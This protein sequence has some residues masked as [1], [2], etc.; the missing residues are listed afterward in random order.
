MPPA[1]PTAPLEPAGAPPAT[2][3]PTTVALFREALPLLLGIFWLLASW[4]VDAEAKRVFVVREPWGQRRTLGYSCLAVGC[5]F[6]L[7]VAALIFSAWGSVRL[8][9]WLYNNQSPSA[10]LR[11]AFLLAG[12]LAAFLA[13]RAALTRW[14]AERSGQS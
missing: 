10:A 3:G 8:I 7:I 14:L 11:A 6:P 13:L 9:L 4:L 1:E 2:P 12:L 5:V